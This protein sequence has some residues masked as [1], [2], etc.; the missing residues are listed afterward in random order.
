MRTELESIDLAT[1]KRAVVSVEEAGE[2]MNLSRGS[3]YKAARSGELPTIR[4]GKR[5]LVSVPCLKAMVGI[6]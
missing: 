4:I 3:A 5:M 6:A 1:E 2:V